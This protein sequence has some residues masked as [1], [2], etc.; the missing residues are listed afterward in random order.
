MITLKSGVLTTI[1]VRVQVSEKDVTVNINTDA[2]R[3]DAW[4]PMSD[5]NQSSVNV[6]FNYETGKVN[7]TVSNAE[8]LTE[9][10]AVVTELTAQI[11]AV[12]TELNSL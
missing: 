6:S 11:K 1:Q 12:V 2:K 8:N 9:A 10:S 5:D 7:T 3:A 4:V